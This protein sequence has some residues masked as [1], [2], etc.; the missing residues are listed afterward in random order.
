MSELATESITPA[1]E[2]KASKNKSISPRIIACGVFRP[3]LAELS[4]IKRYPDLEVK[5]LPANLHLNPK[6][7][8]KMLHVELEASRKAGRR[9]VCLY[10]ECCPD[11]DALCASYGAR[12]VRGCHCYEML[13]GA[14]RYRALMDETAGTFFLESELLRDFERSCA[15]VLE[16]HD[17]EIRKCM[18]AHYRRVVYVR[19]PSDEDLLEQAGEVAR[20]LELAL[21]VMDADYADLDKEL[22]RLLRRRNRNNH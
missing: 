18:F 10:G 21:E 12:R 15:Q 6:H 8:E 17:E 14:D 19:R 3:V 2:L 13:L 7:I 20:F 11:I 9:T 1:K 5:Y 16:L 4:V 22:A